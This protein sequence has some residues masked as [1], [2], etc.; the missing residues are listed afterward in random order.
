MA[1]ASLPRA[2][3]DVLPISLVLVSS[4]ILV[5]SRPR[6]RL[7]RR[8]DKGTSQVGHVSPSTAHAIKH[9]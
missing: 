6:S 1:P 7:P 9:G 8:A 4:D 3:G 2:V 5:I